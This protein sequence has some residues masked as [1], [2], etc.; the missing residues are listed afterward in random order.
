MGLSVGDVVARTLRSMTCLR[1]SE[2]GNTGNKDGGKH[3]ENGMADTPPTPERAPARTEDMTF[4]PG[5]P[6]AT[7]TGSSSTDKKECIMRMYPTT[8]PKL[9]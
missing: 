2:A 5:I 4:Q 8:K 3:M 6:S 9:R 1:P 7:I